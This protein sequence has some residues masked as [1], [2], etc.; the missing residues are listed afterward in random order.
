MKVISF[1]GFNGGKAKELSDLNI[2][3]PINNYGVVED[4]HQ[5]VMHMLAQHFRKTYAVDIDKVKL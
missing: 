4:C 3:I 1:T 5:I 2:H